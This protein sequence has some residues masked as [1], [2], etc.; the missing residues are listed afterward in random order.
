MKF[1]ILKNKRAL[2]PAISGIILVAVSVTYAFVAASW[3]GE[4]TLNVMSLEELKITDCEWAQ[5]FSHADLTIKNIG[6]QAATLNSIQ[7]NRRL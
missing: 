7:V 3:L 2:S 5:D 1:R 6:T 4:I